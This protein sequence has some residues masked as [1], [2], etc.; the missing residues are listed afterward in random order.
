ME[1]RPALLWILAV[2]SAL[3]GALAGIVFE[4]FLDKQLVIAA[5]LRKY[6]IAD[7]VGVAEEVFSTVIGAALGAAFVGLMAFVVYRLFLSARR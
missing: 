2:I 7:D 3:V 1:V 5:I 6:A 4:G